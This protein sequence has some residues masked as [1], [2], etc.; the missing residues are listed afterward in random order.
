M[1]EWCV[2]ILQK[3][4]SSAAYFGKLYTLAIVL[5]KIHIALDEFINQTL[6]IKLTIYK[7]NTYVIN[8]GWVV[9]IHV[10]RD[11]PSAKRQR[12]GGGCFSNFRLKEKIALLKKRSTNHQLIFAD[13]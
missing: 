7:Q 4:G 6:E 9:D 5:R 10:T 3:L 13:L 2:Q 1:Y 11:E 8:D 12:G